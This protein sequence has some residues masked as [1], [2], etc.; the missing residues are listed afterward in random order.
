MRNILLLVD[1][2]EQYLTNDEFFRNLREECIDTAKREMKA[3]YHKII[4]NVKW[5]KDQGWEI[6]FTGENPPYK[7]LEFLIDQTLPYWAKNRMYISRYYN[8]LNN[9]NI[10]IGG[11]FRERCVYEVFQLING[12][13]IDMDLTISHF[14][15]GD[16]ENYIYDLGWRHILPEEMAF[17]LSESQK[18]KIV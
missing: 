9:T 5:L 3:K 12:A 16:E 7:D 10:V 11:L 14:F 6:H 8:N 15:I 2:E 18:E 4:D 13:R 17:V 1:I